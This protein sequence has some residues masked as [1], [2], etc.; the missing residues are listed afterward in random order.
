M[1]KTGETGE[2]ASKREGRMSPQ[3]LY[4]LTYSRNTADAYGRGTGIGNAFTVLAGSRAVA[5]D[6]LGFTTDP[7]S[8]SKRWRDQMIGNKVLVET[9]DGK[10]LRLVSDVTFASPS[11]AASVMCGTPKNGNDAWVLL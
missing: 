3:R 1:E 9:E 4:H 6:R 5:K 8:A 2:K 10:S 7:R 11:M